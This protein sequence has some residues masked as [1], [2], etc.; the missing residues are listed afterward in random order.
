MDIQEDSAPAKN[1]EFSPQKEKRKKCNFKTLEILKP[2]WHWSSEKFIAIIFIKVNLL[3]MY[4][5][6]R[7]RKVVF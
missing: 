4:N 7:K 2:F 5:G 6:E 1:Y 3:S